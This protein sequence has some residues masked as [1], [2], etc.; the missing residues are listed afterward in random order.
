MNNY[1]FLLS[2]FLIIISVHLL[3]MYE[4]WYWD[5]S[6]LDIPMHFFGGF[7]IVILFLWARKHLNFF[8]NNSFLG[9]FI[10]ILGWVSLIGV[11]WE[12]FEFSLDYIWAVKGVIPLSQVSIS[13]T[14]KDLLMDL[15]GGASAF[16][17]QSF[18]FERTRS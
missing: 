7:W 9:D 11:F 8:G 16:F 18:F 3:G 4:N 14:L 6:W 5:I 13:D 17:I 15:L 12:F 10:I 2:L 1:K